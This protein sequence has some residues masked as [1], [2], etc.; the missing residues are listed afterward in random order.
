MKAMG[1][2]VLIVLVMSLLF[3][4]AFGNETVRLTSAQSEIT[5]TLTVDSPNSDNTYTNTMVLDFELGINRPNTTE[6]LGLFLWYMI[7]NNTET[8]LN[9]PGTDIYGGAHVSEFV[10]ISYLSNGTHTLTV[11]AQ[12]PY[13][14]RGGNQTIYPNKQTL[15]PTYFSVDNRP[16]SVRILNPQN[17][18]YTNSTIDLTYQISDPSSSP[19]LTW[20]GY[21]IDNEANQTDWVYVWGNETHSQALTGLTD[22]PHNVTVYVAAGS[23][24][25]S[26]TV[27]FTV[28]TSMSTPTPTFTTTPIPS[29]TPSPTIPEFP[30]WIIFPLIIVATLAARVYAKRTNKQK[31]G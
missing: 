27:S 21:S 22:G 28:S 10:D 1:K 13:L 20:K 14:H 4:I 15:P 3:S 9:N 17:Q 25:T 7:D 16:P 2:K 24:G 26:D 5:F 23:L 29:A 18:T 30:F 19:K 6:S 12:Q 31:L 8:M 11:I